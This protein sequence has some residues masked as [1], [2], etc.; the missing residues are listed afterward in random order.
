MVDEDGFRPNVGI[1]IF[2]DEGKLLWAKRAG[3]NAWQFPQGGIRHNEKP[4]QA[5][6]RELYE[7]VGLEPEDV[8]IVART[9][10]WLPYR[11]PQQFIRQNSHPVCIG[12]KQLWFLMKLLSDTSKIRFDHT[13]KPEFDRWRWVD[14]WS[15]LDEVISFKREVY[16][17]AL[18]EF[19][20]IMTRKLPRSEEK[21]KRAPA[22]TP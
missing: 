1:I 8:E 19:S 7:E 10:K 4:E 11:L 14:Y 3:Q 18:E 5:A 17:R 22:S 21:N 6:I 16:R 15:P 13:D 20:Q 9:G 12:Q 2:N